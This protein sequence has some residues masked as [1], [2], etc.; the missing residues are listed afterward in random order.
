MSRESFAGQHVSDCELGFCACLG[1]S[2]P[3]AE[4]VVPFRKWGD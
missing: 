3:W 2:F 4:L 1:F